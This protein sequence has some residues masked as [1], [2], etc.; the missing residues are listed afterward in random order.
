MPRGFTLVEL[1]VVVAIIGILVGLLLP[2]VQSVRGSARRTHC[3]SN[4][5]Q[6]GFAMGQFCD[7][8]RGRFPFTGHTAGGDP[9]KS[10][11]YT[12][13]PFMESV[14][15]VRVCPD[16]KKGAERLSA[17]LTSYVMNAYLTSEPTGH[18]ARYLVTNRDKLRQTSK[19]VVAF[20]LS[21]QKA[22]SADDDHLH[23][24][25]WF[26]Q[27]TVARRTVLKEIRDDVSIERHAGASHFLFA[28]WRV[29]SIP[30]SQVAAWAATQNRTN[31][32]CLPNSCIVP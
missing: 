8:H 3:A 2:A 21:D 14:D 30:N 11:I 4:L 31:N 26:T 27:D 12:V 13:A 15:A 20:E 25:L 28:D 19:T 5:R 16:D 23:N 6:V 7:T 18:P 24:H 29:A 1:L 10:W 9:N 22:V 17:R 32:F